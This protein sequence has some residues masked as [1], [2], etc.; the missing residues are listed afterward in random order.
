MNRFSLYFPSVELLNHS[1]AAVVAAACHC[2]GQIV[3]RNDLPL[4]NRN[5]KIPLK[6]GG[7]D[8]LRLIN[9]TD[10]NKP[11]TDAADA[12]ASQVIVEGQHNPLTKLKIVEKLLDLTVEKNV[13]HKVST[14]LIIPNNLRFRF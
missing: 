6:Y 11:A 10:N 2:I 8:G 4:P 1:V 9:E 14:S 7:F 12:S 13:A 5:L 3:R